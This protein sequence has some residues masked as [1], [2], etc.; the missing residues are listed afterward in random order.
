[1]FVILDRKT[2]EPRLVKVPTPAT[3]I[4]RV[5]SQ[6]VRCGNPTKK[7][8]HLPILAGAKDQVPMIPHQGKTEY[9]HRVLFDSFAKHAQK[10]FV[11]CLFLKN[12]L[13]QIPPVQGMINLPGEIVTFLPWHFSTSVARDEIVQLRPD[14]PPSR[15]LRPSRFLSHS[16]FQAGFIPAH[17]VPFSFA[18]V[19]I[20]R[21]WSTCR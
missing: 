4:V 11:V 14:Q 3:M 2:L 19:V 15:F 13:P 12:R 8:S 20:I 16:L 10:G 1:M 6:Y 21:T 17:H 9:L 7:A 5:V 18:E